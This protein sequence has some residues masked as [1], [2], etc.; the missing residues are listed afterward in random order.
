[1]RGGKDPLSIYTFPLSNKSLEILEKKLISM[2]EQERVMTSV[3]LKLCQISKYK[4]VDGVGS[5]KY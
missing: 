2:E 4:K 5:L 1:M 3:S